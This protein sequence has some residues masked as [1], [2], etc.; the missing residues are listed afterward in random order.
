MKMNER[1]YEKHSSDSI[2]IHAKT[3]EYKR[4]DA[5]VCL[6]HTAD[7][8]FI[9]RRSCPPLSVEKNTMRKRQIIASVSTVMLAVIYV[10]YVFV[11][12]RIGD[13]ANNH[14]SEVGWYTVLPLQGCCL[15][16]GMWELRKTR[17]GIVAQIPVALSS[18]GLVLFFAELSALVGGV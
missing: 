4:S 6:N 5:D 17:R 10:G 1:L 7:G 16:W 3:I 15:L 18:A 8:T 11:D 14:A 9:C 13:V 2:P 12:A